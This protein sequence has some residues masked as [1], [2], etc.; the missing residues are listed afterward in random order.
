[1]NLASWQSIA[2]DSRGRGFDSQPKGQELHFCNRSRLGLKVEVSR[3][4][5]F[6]FVKII[7]LYVLFK[8][9]AGVPY[10]DLFFI[11]KF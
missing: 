4:T 7:D 8:N 1:M 9:R 11:L 2:L 10:R 6:S 3:Y 5:R